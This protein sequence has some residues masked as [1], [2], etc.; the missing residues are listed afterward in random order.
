MTQLRSHMPWNARPWQTNAALLL[1][2]LA[3]IEVTRRLVVE[4]DGFVVGY[5]PLAGASLTLWLAASVILLLLPAQVNRWTFPLLIAVAVACRLV[6]LF[7]EPH[8]S[9]DVYR[10]C[11]DGV[12]QHAHISPYRF[13]ASNPALTFLRAPNQDLYDHMNRRDY[14]HTIYPPGA[15]VLFY[16]ITWINPEVTM[17]KLAMVL[18][19]GLTMWALVALL[20]HLAVPREQ[21]ILYAWCPLLIWEF[22]GSGHLDSAA[23]AF[24]MLAVL[25]RYRRQPVAVGIFLGLA[26]LIKFYPVILLPALYQRGRDRGKAPGWAMPAII[27]GLFVAFYSVYLSAGK[28]VF[29]F[30]GGYVQEE[31]MASGTRY[32]LLELVQHLPGLHTL[33]SIVYLAFAALV[34]LVLTVW[35]WRTASIPDAAPQAFLIPCL[36]L[37]AALMLLFSPHYPWYIAWLVPF[38][39]LLPNLPLLTYISAFFYLCTTALA[40]GYGPKQF[41]LNEYLYGAILLAVIMSVTAKYLDLPRILHLEPQRNS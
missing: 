29:G 26:I 41:L 40:E 1:L 17:M 23:I 19:E 18:F 37:A 31:G 36:A 6:V 2:G 4:Y 14:A 30:L 3:L 34:F 16:L 38:L 28:L 39:V 11:W 21:S 15:Q 20:R 27:A 7:P 9:S 8:L 33:P 35:S 24:I 22:A 25:F 32:F 5:S 10:Y 12:V 13:V